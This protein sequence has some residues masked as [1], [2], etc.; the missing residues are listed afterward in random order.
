MLRCRRSTGRR[1]T[2]LSARNSWHSPWCQSGRGTVVHRRQTP[3]SRQRRVRP[4]LTPAPTTRGTE[5]GAPQG[6]SGRAVAAEGES[7]RRAHFPHPARAELREPAAQNLLADGDDVVEI[8]GTGLTHS[9][10]H[11]EGDFGG[12]P[13]DCRADG[14]DGDAGEIGDR[15][16]ARQ[17]EHGPPLVRRRKAAEADL[18]SL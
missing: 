13:P 5:T 7:Q 8:G 10:F 4:A 11:A 12:N 14:R 3:G 9:V 6:S 18:P 15:A 1:P 16:R 17:D 2:N